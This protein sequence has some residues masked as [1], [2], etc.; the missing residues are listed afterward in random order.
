M[1]CLSGVVALL[2]YGSDRSNELVQKMCQALGHRG[3]DDSGCF[4]DSRVALGNVA[5]FRG[6]E[7]VH[8]PLCNKKKDIWITFDGAIYNS[9]ELRKHFDEETFLP[10]SDPEL[11]LHA[12][13]KDDLDCLKWLDGIFAFCIWDSSRGRLVSARDRFGIKTLYYHSIGDKC[14]FSSEIKTI[15]VDS[16]ITRTP[17]HDLLCK[18]LKAPGYHFRSGDT[19]F[20]Q[21]KEVLPGHYTV[22]DFEKNKLQVH[23]YWHLPTSSVPKKGN[24]SYPLLLLDKLSNAVK[25]M[26]PKDVRFATCLSGGLDSQ[27]IASLIDE[28]AKTHDTS[29]HTLVSAVCPKASK[30]YNEEPYI[31]EYG[32]F[33]GTQ[34]KYVPFPNSPG[35][36]EIK[37]FVYCLEEPN[38]QLN[39]YLFLHLAEELKN[40]GVKVAFLGTGVDLFLWSFE[41]ER[42]AYLKSLREEKDFGTLLIELIGMVVHQVFYGYPFW[43][44]VERAKGIVM[45]SRAIFDSSQFLNEQYITQ[46]Y[47]RAEDSL[48]DRTV[49]GVVMNTEALDKVF[50]AFSVEPRYPALDIEF[51]LL[52]NSLPA[53]QR[54]RRGVTKFIM[55]EATKGL[56]PEAVRKSPRKFGT[57]IPLVEW[58]TDLRPE[59]VQMLS[60][61][62]F[63]ERKIFNQEKILKTFDLLCNGKLD[64]PNVIPFCIFLWTV[65]DLELWFQIYIDSSTSTLLD[66]ARARH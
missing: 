9:G 7:I 33:R 66:W 62:E 40:E 46:N 3:P 22:F 50:T 57:S 47:V 42:D 43:M 36:K 8:Q 28:L 32:R 16:T 10:V 49:G 39:F 1:S 41:Y 11:V 51:A 19:F 27:T 6:S 45:P 18:Y 54:I 53:N 61:R 14:I 52:M 13:E 58:L 29:K 17:N 31:R 48:V 4:V 5:S 24:G 59:I 38:V 15:F 2:G 26:L 60:S 35:W 44:L 12:Y 20:A 21:I 30:R 63:K 37:D 65:V 55:R 64:P 34:I 23:E 25:K 56:I